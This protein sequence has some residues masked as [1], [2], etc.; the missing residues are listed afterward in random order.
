MLPTAEQKGEPGIPSAENALQNLYP[1]ARA[2]CGPSGELV[3]KLRRFFV[4]V[5]SQAVLVLLPLSSEHEYEY[6]YGYEMGVGVTRSC[7]VAAAGP[8]VAPVRA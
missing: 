7:L 8:S 5:L 6:E 3:L 1:I 4:L 2:L